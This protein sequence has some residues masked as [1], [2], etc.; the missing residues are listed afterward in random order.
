LEQSGSDNHRRTREIVGVFDA[1]RVYYEILCDS[2]G[3][4][5]AS[6][7]VRSNLTHDNQY[8]ESDQNNTDD[9]GATVAESVTV[10]AEAATEAAK[11]KNIEDDNDDVPS[12]M[13]Y[14]L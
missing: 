10:S 14:L 3:D 5:P 2:V 8:D 13:I 4:P 7:F 9:A 6:L 11:Q 12:D 1:R